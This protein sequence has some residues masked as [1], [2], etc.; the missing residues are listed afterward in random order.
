MNTKAHATVRGHCVRKIKR[1]FHGKIWSW[2]RFNPA[3]NFFLWLWSCWVK[4]KL[5]RFQCAFWIKSNILIDFIKNECFYNV[6]TQVF[7]V[8][9][10]IHYKRIS[11]TFKVSKEQGAKV[12]F[13]L[14]PS[15]NVLFFM[16]FLT[17]HK[18][19]NF[20]KKPLCY[21][22]LINSESTN[23]FFFNLE[24]SAKYQAR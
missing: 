21:E 9:R 13:Q 23:A 3:L 4:P 11:A 15:S 8:G 22:V 12:T 2:H 16:L 24:D 1:L 5:S 18:A 7:F 10:S 6:L 17:R 14:P 19:L 20:I